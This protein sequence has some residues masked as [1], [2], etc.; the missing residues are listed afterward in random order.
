MNPFSLFTNQNC[1]TEKFQL[2]SGLS[3][4]DSH[5][6]KTLLKTFSTERN[7]QFKAQ[8]YFQ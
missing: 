7:S 8:K 2:S 4:P 1:S 5:A 6:Q 3:K